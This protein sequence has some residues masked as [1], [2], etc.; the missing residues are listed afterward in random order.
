MRALISFLFIF[1]SISIVF[2]Q[3]RYVEPIDKHTFELEGITQFQQ[4]SNYSSFGSGY[5]YYGFGI[6]HKYS[7]N[8]TFGLRQSV[9]Y[10]NNNHDITNL[11]RGRA[12]FRHLIYSIEG[13]FS[14]GK[15]QTWAANF[16][17]SAERKRKGFDQDYIYSSNRNSFIDMNNLGIQFGVGRR[18]QLNNKY[19]FSV[20]YSGSYFGGFRHG[21]R[22]AYLIPKK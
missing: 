19:K 11:G 6:A 17:F 12:S 20:G 21:V 1:L 22:L 9:R 4:Y 14:I 13:V 7:F 5:K 16:G 10:L 18:F 15:N 2:S 3:D 8:S